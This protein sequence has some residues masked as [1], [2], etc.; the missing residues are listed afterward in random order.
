MRGA[1]TPKRWVDAV[2]PPWHQN[3]SGP[4]NGDVNASAV[5]V[6]P[7]GTKIFVT[8]TSTAL[9]QV[10]T[11]PPSRTASEIPPDAPHFGSRSPCR[12]IV[13]VRPHKMILTAGAGRIGFDVQIA[14]GDQFLGKIVNSELLD[15]SLGL[16]V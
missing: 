6:S 11:L 10:P 4:G 15:A 16:I 8:G 2:P 7:D 3:Y 12:L 13:F 14:L 5:A 9:V 1:E